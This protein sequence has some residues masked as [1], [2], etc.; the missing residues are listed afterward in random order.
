MSWLLGGEGLDSDSLGPGW[1]P[2]AKQGLGAVWGRGC[3]P[4]A[5]VPV[6]RGAI[7]ALGT[8][9]TSCGPGCCASAWAGTL[10][11]AKVMCSSVPGHWACSDVSGC[12]QW[13]AEP[14]RPEEACQ[15]L[16]LQGSWPAL[17]G[18]GCEE[19]SVMPRRSYQH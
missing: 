12:R 13:D 17:L 15:P 1:A 18:H 10:S 3:A 19:A 8:W 9:V 11:R 7:A 16:W 4:R 6:A 14:V 5:A 2:Q